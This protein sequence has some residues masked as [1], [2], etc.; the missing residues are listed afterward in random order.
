[1]ARPNCCVFSYD[2][3]LFEHCGS[4]EVH[5]VFPHAWQL[6][7]ARREIVSVVA[8]S[9]NGPLTARVRAL[10]RATPGMP[11]TLHK[12]QLAV[13][14]TVISFEGARPWIVSARRS[15]M[16]DPSVL[17]QDL[18]GLRHQARAAGRGDLAAG[19]EDMWE[20]GDGCWRRVAGPSTRGDATAGWLVR[21]R[22]EIAALCEALV[23]GDETGASQHAVGLLG[24]G[25]GLTPAGDDVVC[26]LLAGLSVLGRRSTRHGRRCSDA[27]AALTHCIAA[28]APRRTTSFSGTLL[29]A[30]TRGVAAE[31]LLRVLETAGS[32]TPMSGVDDVLMLG[33][34]SG[35]DML[36]GALLAGAT[37]V[38]WEE[39][40]GPAV[41][42]SR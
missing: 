32:G 36:T 23:G 4:L 30:A 22:E 6:R 16:L 15:E 34:S 37:L 29:R 1:M 13:G 40:F 3:E 21:G 2:P 27:L 12:T 10:P 42:G 35:S 25:P 39:L 8:S 20:G 31:P 9:W 38:R 17:R 11:A 24:L 14:N 18:D 26:G 41:V 19:I 7:T 5:A 33:H 28:E